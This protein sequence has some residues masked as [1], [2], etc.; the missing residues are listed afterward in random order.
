MARELAAP[1]RRAGVRSPRSNAVVRGEEIGVR[2]CAQRARSPRA[3]EPSTAGRCE[4]EKARI[5]GFIGAIVGPQAVR[6]LRNREQL[7]DVMRGTTSRERAPRFARH[8]GA[9]V[10]AAFRAECRRDCH[11]GGAGWHNA[12]PRRWSASS[13]AATATGT[14]CATRPRSSTRSAFALRGA[15][16]VGA[17]HARRHVR[18]RRRRAARAACAC[19]IAGA[20]GAAHLPG[21]LAAKTT[22]PVLGVPVPSKYLRGEDSLL[23]DRPD[24]EGHPGRDLRD[25]RGRRGERRRSSRSRCS[26]RPIPSV[27]QEARRVPAEADERPRAR[28]TCRPTASTAG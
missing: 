12:K 4:R 17:P 15:R 19:I 18:V 28:C 25:R 6:I 27:A 5:D 3:S 2:R 20:G 14:S 26:P 9:R 1:A 23:F 11:P 16:A 8:P 13:W 21:M 22:V 7:R 24:A 10:A